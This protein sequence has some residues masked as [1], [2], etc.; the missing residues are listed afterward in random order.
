MGPILRI[1]FVYVVIAAVGL[2]AL[3]PL[4]TPGKAQAFPSTTGLLPTPSTVPASSPAEPANPSGSGAPRPRRLYLPAM[5]DVWHQPPSKG[6]ALTSDNCR[7]AVAAGVRWTY[8]YSPD[9]VDCS[10]FGIESVPM[11]ATSKAIDDIRNGST[12]LGGNGRYVMGFNEPDGTSQ[13][14]LTPTQAATLWHDQVEPLAA[15]KK[16]VGPVVMQW[17]D[18]G[19]N[20]GKINPATGLAY[21]PDDCPTPRGGWWLHQFRRDYINRY[22]RPPRID[23]MP[24]HAYHWWGELH[25][26]EVAAWFETFTAQRIALAN[27]WG[28]P[29]VWITEFNANAGAKAYPVFPECQGVGPTTPRTPAT[30]SCYPALSQAQVTAE[31]GAYIDWLKRQPKVTRFAWFSARQQGTEWWSCGHVGTAVPT[32]LCDRPLIVWGSSLTAP[33]LT[34]D[35]AAYKLK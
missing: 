29:E 18:C 15:G 23:V 12:H 28:V 35:G 33:V 21:T 19:D 17:E 30:A 8:D 31:S 3:S 26:G 4:N 24:V 25:S 5:F 22:G 1:R 13:A 11:L 6:M 14:D 32:P 2:A 9:P 34:A 20:Q 10:Q 7:D 27:A 16:L